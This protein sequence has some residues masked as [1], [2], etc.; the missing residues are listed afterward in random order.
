MSHKKTGF[1]EAAMRNRNIVILIAVLFM[2]IGAVALKKMPRNEFPQFTIRQ[3][4]IVGVYP[5]ANIGRS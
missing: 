2:V 3:G 5:G 4:V 1:I